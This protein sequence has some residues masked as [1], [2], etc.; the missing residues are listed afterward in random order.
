MPAITTIVS[1][2]NLLPFEPRVENIDELMTG[3]KD[4]GVTHVQ[5][6]HLTEPMH[7]EHLA[8]P[9][10]VYLWFAN[11]APPPRPLMRMAPS[12]KSSSAIMASRSVPT[13]TASACPPV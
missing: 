6:N 7:P 3:L 5:V 10:N 11:Y 9:D 4:A 12:A 2:P 13:P 8:Q 1:Y